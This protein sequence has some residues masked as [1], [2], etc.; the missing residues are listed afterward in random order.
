M[1]PIICVTPN[2]ALDLTLVVPDFK[3]GRV[4]RASQSISAAGGKGVERSACN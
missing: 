1:Q 3:T 4:M 2:P